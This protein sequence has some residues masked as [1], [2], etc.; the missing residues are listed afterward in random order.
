MGFKLSWIRRILLIFPRAA[1]KR[2]EQIG[3]GTAVLCPC[4]ARGQRWLRGIQPRLTRC[5]PGLRGWAGGAGTAVRSSRGSVLFVALCWSLAVSAL[6]SRAAATDEVRRFCS[7]ARSVHGFVGGDLGSVVTAGV[8]VPEPSPCCPAP[9]T[10]VPWLIYT[11]VCAQGVCL[12][13][14]GRC[15]GGE[16]GG[17]AEVLDLVHLAALGHGAAPIHSFACQLSQTDH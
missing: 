7:R 8:E 2:K 13:G 5:L 16:S 1:K 17:R 4:R 15:E 6:P 3:A 12:A 11:C 10:D 9:G 14:S